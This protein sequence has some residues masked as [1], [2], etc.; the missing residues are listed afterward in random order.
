MTTKEKIIEQAEKQFIKKGIV[1]TQIKDIAS[2]VNIN[3]RTLYRYFPTKDVLAFN[4]EMIVMEKIKRY[5][6]VPN[7]LVNNLNGY[8]KVKLYFSR[9][10]FNEIKDLMKFTAEFDRYF[11]EE[12][13]TP[14]LEESF[15]KILKPEDNQ[16]Y[17]FIK[18]GLLDGSI[19]KDLSL[20]SIY[21]FVSNNFFALFQRLILRE[22]HLINEHCENV[23]FH[24]LFIDIILS[25][26]KG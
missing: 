2:E 21:H 24:S 20:D 4:V 8:D 7:N 19:R 1:N 6:E 11:Q 10:K 3:R 14:Q 15:I 22:Q 18:D 9:V 26:I 12:Y 25:G 17:N 23:D 13:P 16:L 5:L